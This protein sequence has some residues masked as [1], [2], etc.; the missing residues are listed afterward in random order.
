MTLLHL[1]PK[2]IIS[3]RITGAT[4][5]AFG[6]FILFDSAQ[7]FLKTSALSSNKRR[8]CTLQR[9]LDLTATFICQ[10]TQYLREQTEALAKKRLHLSSFYTR[11]SLN[12]ICEA[13]FV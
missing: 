8:T 10:H 5:A 7:H 3:S 12:Q 4:V 9:A 13:L 6:H 2:L 11:L 1:M